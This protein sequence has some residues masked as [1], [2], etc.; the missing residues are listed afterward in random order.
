MLGI[1]DLSGELM[2]HAIN[3]VGMGR[4]D[5]THAVHHFLIDMYRGRCLNLRRIKS[6]ILI[7]TCAN[8]V[9]LHIVLHG[10]RV[11]VTDGALMRAF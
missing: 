8:V 2:R 6:M 1:A 10:S 9:I 4:L 7:Y 5:V 11:R 3:A